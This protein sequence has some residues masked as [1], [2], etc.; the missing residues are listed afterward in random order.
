M[1]RSP[2]TGGTGQTRPGGPSPS[3]GRWGITGQRAGAV[4]DAHGASGAVWPRPL[5]R[6]PPEQ[7]KATGKWRNNIRA[8]DRGASQSR[9]TT[10]EA[11][12]SAAGSQRAQRQ[13]E[14]E[15][16]IQGT[17]QTRLLRERE[18][19][20]ATVSR[21]VP[22]RGVSHRQAVISGSFPLTNRYTSPE[23]DLTNRYT[24]PKKDL[25]NRYTSRRA[26]INTSS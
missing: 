14:L 23:E 18:R 12:V 20:K 21:S 25:T 17:P 1:C 2:G 26:S 22:K 19:Q 16:G 6:S 13:N 9:R 4:T 3:A 15:S 5:R 8:V 7:G 24:S 11:G 10:G